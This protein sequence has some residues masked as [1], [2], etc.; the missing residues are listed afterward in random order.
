MPPHRDPAGKQLLITHARSSGDHSQMLSKDREDEARLLGATY[1]NADSLVNKNYPHLEDAHDFEASGRPSKRRR[2]EGLKAVDL[3]HE[4]LAGPA[5]SVHEVSVSGHR[6]SRLSPGSTFSPAKPRSNGRPTWHPEYRVVEDMLRCERSP[7]NRTRDRLPSH[8]GSLDEQFTAGA[9]VQRRYSGFNVDN[10]DQQPTQA[11]LDPLRLKRNVLGS[12]EIAAPKGNTSEQI[13]SQTGTQPSIPSN[14]ARIAPDSGDSPDELQGEVTT[15]PVPKRLEEKHNQKRRKQLHEQIM[16]SPSRKRS[17]ADIEPTDFARSPRQGLKK[18]KHENRGSESALFYIL[19][20]RF[21]TISKT[22]ENGEEVVIRVSDDRIELGKAITG[23]KPVEVLLRHIRSAYQGEDKVRL[24][25][26]HYQGSPGAYVD[27]HFSREASKRRF[28]QLLEKW[29]DEVPEKDSK[30]ME[31]LFSRYD[32][33]MLQHGNNAK[34]PFLDFAPSPPPSTSVKHA[35]G[36]KLSSMLEG[37]ADESEEHEEDGNRSEPQE[38][39]NSIDGA[40]EFQEMPNG[41]K[42]DADTRVEIP[43]KKSYGVQSRQRETRPATRRTTRLSDRLNCDD[44]SADKTD[45]ALQNDTFRKNWK[46]PLV[47]PKNGKKKEEVSVEDR[48]RLRENEFLNDNLI[49]FYMRFLQNHLERTNPEAA[50]RVYFFNSYFFA[51]LTNKGSREIN[52]SGIEKWTRNV[53]LFSY[54]YIVVP[55]NQN[56]HW[57]VAIICN[58]PSLVLDPAVRLES[59]APM[60]DKESLNPPQKEVQEVAESSKPEPA[61]VSA[62][63]SEEEPEKEQRPAPISP[64]SEEA[65]QSFASMS[66]LEQQN[67]CVET[68]EQK[69]PTSRT[70]DG[71]SLEHTPL[72]SAAILPAHQEHPAPTSQQSGKTKKKRGG[73]KL[74]PRQ[75]AIITFDS[76]DLARSPTIRLLRDYICK[77]AAS[78]RAMEIKNPLAEIKGMRAQNIP[79]QPN[80]SDCGLYLL[81]YLEKFVQSPDQFITKLLQREMNVHDDWPLLGSG[82]LRLRLRDFLDQLYQEQ[83]SDKK[84][85]LMVDRQPISFLLGPPGPNREDADGQPQ[86]TEAQDFAASSKGD[87]T[88]GKKDVEDRAPQE[89]GELSD[90]ATSDLPDLVPIDPRASHNSTRETAEPPAADIVQLRPPANDPDVHGIPD[91]Q[92]L[93]T[94]ASTR[95]DPASSHKEKKK[96]GKAHEDAPI[97]KADRKRP[98]TPD[99][100][101]VLNLEAVTHKSAHSPIIE[102]RV[103]PTVQV[104]RTPPRQ[105]ARQVRKSPR[106]MTWKS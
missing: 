27:I 84:E 15:Q 20:V 78:K 54:D 85:D 106:G 4:D 19:S 92:E 33:E 47:Y 14:M 57:Y 89:S 82:L 65:R 1:Q 3:T 55:I 10:A 91:S 23:G 98:T 53:D 46:E 8:T 76:L 62:K 95:S 9:A 64:H 18:S 88:A 31:K 60:S 13:Q 101:E 58:L 2:Q 71:P 12:I 49:A 39:S 43:V 75:A 17:P 80:Y 67:A 50:N 79:L 70:Q 24:Q 6:S 36:Q 102:V 34:A 74:D 77:E 103:P 63:P 26:S 97:R 42:Q 32:R 28:V 21:G 45:P 48:D 25:L 35:T 61:P 68:E 11:Y 22:V 86:K 99:N 94:S 44:A 73:V 81:A 37:S 59:P 96:P 16:V 72:S 38:S 29:C 87:E 90:S 5:S 93:P 52:Y 83:A 56:A 104:P 30:H 105:E 100:T 41:R 40:G 7:R 69:R 51:T 66:L